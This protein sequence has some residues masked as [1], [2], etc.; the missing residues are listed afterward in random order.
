MAGEHGGQ[1]HAVAQALGREVGDVLDFSASINPL[2]PPPWLR[3]VVSRSLDVVQH[4]PWPRAEGVRQA[5]SRRYGVPVAQIAVGA[6]TSELLFALPRVLGLSRA[7]VPVPCYGDYGRACQAAGLQVTYL[8]PGP[9]LVPDLDVLDAALAQG[10]AV[11]LVGHPGNPVGQPLPVGAFTALIRC[12]PESFWVVDEAFADFI[13]GMARFFGVEAPNLAVLLSLTKIY[14]V[15]A[16]RVGLMVAPP[17]VVER[18]E[19]VL[20]PWNVCGPAQAVAEAAL[21]DRVFAADSA[22]QIQLWRQELVAGI[23]TL[24]GWE[25]IPGQANYVLCRVAHG[26]RPVSDAL[27]QRGI[28][29]R[30]CDSIPGLDH[31]YLRL[32]VR[33]PAENTRL[34]EAL[35]EVCTGR[36]RSRQRRTPALMVAGCTSDAGKSVLV[37]GLCRILWQDGLRV[38]PFKAQNMSLNSAVTPLGGEMGRAQ[39]VQARACGLEPDVRMN[40]VLIKPRTDTGAQIVVLG[41]PWADLDVEGYRQAKARLWPIITAAYAELAAAADVVLLEGAG[42]PAEVNL[43]ADDVVN[44][45]MA[46]HAGARVLL[47]GDIDRGGVFAAFVGTVEVLDPWERQLIAGFVINKFRGRQELLEPAIAYLER[48][49]GRRLVGIVPYLGE[50]GLPDEDSVAFKAAGRSTGQGEVVVAVVDL[51]RISNATDIDPLRLE[52]D[53]HLVRARTPEDLRGACA[54]ILPGSRSVP[55]DLG[56]LRATG[57]ADA[58]IQAARA[59]VE[60]IGICGGLQMLGNAIKDPF[61][62]E[63]QRQEEVAGLGLLPLVT[64][65]R[66]AKELTQTSARHLESGLEVVGYEIHHGQTRAEGEVD[67]LMVRPDGAVIGWGRGRVWGTYLHGLWDADLFRWYMLDCWRARMGLPQRGQGAVYDLGK[68]LDRLAQALRQSLDLDQVYR[69][70]GL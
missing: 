44:L 12:H 26:A 3:G 24:P 57:L 22:R 68:A 36:T 4:Y 62:V 30:V 17:P 27:L 37:A 29:L 28:V 49:T 5:A 55:Q 23:A 56:F 15:P 40:P 7:I 13:P 42:S 8:P 41:K 53:I 54:I 63:G 61:G 65:F 10:P 20:P 46:R 69:L 21:A 33:T 34:L 58:I 64:V 32:A 67:P 48:F 43:K 59:G 51:P 18:L 70:L 2:G 35:E 25:I 50:L 52:P 9:G 11:V 66:E 38:V 19:A 14:A 6:G 39:A 1:V 45:R 47:A 60:V 16:L 31:H